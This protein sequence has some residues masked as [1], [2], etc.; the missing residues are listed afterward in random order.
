MAQPSSPTALSG[1]TAAG[2][3]RSHAAS[4]AVRASWERIAHDPAARSRR[5]APARL[6]AA[7]KVIAELSA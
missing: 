7:R 4:V 2:S 1:T 5:T 6:A 3:R